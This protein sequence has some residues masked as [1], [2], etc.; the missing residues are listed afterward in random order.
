MKAFSVLSLV[1][2][3]P[4]EAGREACRNTSLSWQRR[5]GFSRRMLTGAAWN[6]AASRG[7]FTTLHMECILFPWFLV[8][9]RQLASRGLGAS[10]QKGGC[11][12]LGGGIQTSGA[13]N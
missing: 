4:L 8:P 7:L 12:S 1:I 13:G 10:Y 6:G 2:R 9:E 11:V 5:Q 3:H